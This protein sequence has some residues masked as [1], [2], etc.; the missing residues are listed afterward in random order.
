MSKEDQPR[1]R[2]EAADPLRL[3]YPYVPEK[4]FILDSGKEEGDDSS[5]NS[6]Y[7]IL[8]KGGVLD[9]QYTEEATNQEF[10]RNQIHLA[11]PRSTTL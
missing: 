10:G 4:S 7:R 8:K 11:E 5:N 6:N 9:L 2:E 1:E 3:V